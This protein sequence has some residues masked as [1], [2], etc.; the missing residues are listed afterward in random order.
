MA[1]YFKALAIPSSS[2]LMFGKAT[3][4]VE[5]GFGLKLGKGEVYPEL[6][7]TLPTMALDEST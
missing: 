3:K 6:N 2:G 4:T 5:C 7:F 1:G